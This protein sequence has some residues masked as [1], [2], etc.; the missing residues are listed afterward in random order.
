MSHLRFTLFAASVALAFFLGMVAFLEVGRRLGARQIA[1][2]GAE[3]RVGVGI[4]DG[5]VYG[6][7]GLLIGF[8]FSGA[9]GRFDQ[10]RLLV[11]E[12]ANAMSTAWKR[13]D[14]LPV[15]QRTTV[16]DGFRRYVDAVLAWYSETP[17]SF[18]AVYQPTDVSRAEDD[19]WSQS[20]AETLTKSGE[21]ARILLLPALNDVFG[22]VERE[23]AARRIHPPFIIFAMLGIT[24]L[25]TALFAGYGMATTSTRNW[26]YMLG[27]AATV[28]LATYV[29]VELEYPRLG[30]VR[31]NAID[32][33][34]RDVR[35]SME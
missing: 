7:L 14:L 10:R 33:A 28:S 24:A 9:A 11:A 23:R 32:A 29:I 17:G 8:S 16:R 31:A 22:A 5:S 25:A 15:P 35:A 34:L 27:I 18:E 19:V 1:K 6:L 21:P 3:A 13:I 26:I 20:V 2:R 12:E 4:V 30:L